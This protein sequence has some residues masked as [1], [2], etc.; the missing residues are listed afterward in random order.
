[1]QLISGIPIN[2]LH[3]S[4][5]VGAVYQLGVIAGVLTSNMFD[6]YA[7]EVSGC[8]A[9]V[10]SLFGLYMADLVRFI[11]KKKSKY[12]HIYIHDSYNERKFCIYYYY[13]HHHYYY[14][15]YYYYCYDY[16]SE[17]IYSCV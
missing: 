11:R 13:Y 9:G 16:L 15:Y 4:L 12:T 7:Y 1:M 17:Y 10:Y 8:S 14:Y 3:G 5:R 2:M 6:P